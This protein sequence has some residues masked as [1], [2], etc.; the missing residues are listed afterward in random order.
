MLI[1]ANAG[2]SRLIPTV[3]GNRPDSPAQAAAPPV[4]PHSRGEQG[5]YFAPRKVVGG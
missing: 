2:R 4:N 5:H 1:M 3:V